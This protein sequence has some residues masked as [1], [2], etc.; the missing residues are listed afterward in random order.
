MVIITDKCVGCGI[1]VKNCPVNALKLVSVGEKKRKAEVDDRCIECGICVRVCPFSAIEKPA[2][3]SP[4]AT[5]CTSC[6]VQ[7]RIPEGRTGA[8]KRYT[9]E[10][11]TLVRNRKL[12][13]N[14]EKCEKA[15]PPS[16][17]QKP[18]ITGVGAGSNY[19]CIRPAPHI[20]SDIRDGV[21]VVTVVTEAPLSY[22]GVTLK[23]DTNTYIGEEGDPVYRDNKIVGLVETEQYGS[24]MIAI[25]G[26]NL[27]TGKDGFIVARTIVE[28][29]NGEEVTLK[30]NKKITVT[31]QHG[32]A[33]IINGVQE[34]VMRIG[35]GS[36]TIGLF[37]DRMKEAVDE[38][39]VIDHHVV[40]LLSEHLAG[41]EVGLTWTGVVPNAT[42]SSAG[43]YFGEHGEGIGGTTIATPRDAI[44]SIDMNLAK[45]GMTILVTNTTGEI[46]EMFEVLEDGD[47][48]SIPMTDK[49]MEL[50]QTIT[51]N[52][53]QSTTSVLYVGG[54][55]GSARGGVCKRPVGITE[56]VHANKAVLTIG[57]APAFV[58]PG[59]GINFMVDTGKVVNKAFTWIPTP[60]TVC[61]VEYTM[62]RE[63][64]EAIEGHISEIRPVEEVRKEFE[65]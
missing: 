41:R 36:A 11:G 56:A 50:V 35:C 18:L 27:L 1:C 40:G 31:V 8:C 13:L 34:S 28:L 38:C 7:C 43:R 64:Y 10:G 3:P 65:G 4:E 60:A 25:G 29:A 58:M 12:V 24:K 61:P 32:N 54:T 49:A 33:P 16:I 2:E 57:G 47:V 37:A 15:Y 52:C 45:P 62:T 46:Y 39:I 59:G 6:P 63:D 20:V 22:S 48:K 21:E 14:N 23:L 19:P 42:R 26:A 5:V 44:K 55:G 17:L 53:Q 51:N 9:N 30:V